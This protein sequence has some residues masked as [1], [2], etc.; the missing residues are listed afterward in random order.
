MNERDLI[1]KASAHEAVSSNTTE[2][3]KDIGQERV[4]DS[5]GDELYTYEAMVDEEGKPMLDETGK[6]IIEKKLRADIERGKFDQTM[7]EK[8]SANY[9]RDNI[10]SEEVQLPDKKVIVRYVPKETLHP[11]FGKAETGGTRAVV[12]EDLP[13]R[14]KKFVKAHEIAH[15]ADT[16][17]W[18]GALGSE[19]R[20][21]VKPALKDPIGFLATAWATLTSA[22]RIKLYFRR[23]KERW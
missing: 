4:E 11:L 19:I 15:C 7:P 18:G 10:P 20:A 8:S 17:T 6:T 2:G 3:P 12:R 5:E 22:D 16:K 1:K 14:V 23:I 21:T 9:P 13:P